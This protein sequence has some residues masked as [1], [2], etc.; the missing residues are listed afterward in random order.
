MNIRHPT[1]GAPGHGNAVAGGGVRVGGVQIDLARAAGGEHGLVGQ[2][3][4][5]LVGMAVQYIGP[6]A[7]RLGLTKLFAQDQVQ[8]D[9]V[10]QYFDIRVGQHL[11]R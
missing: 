5:D 6:Q 2:Q 3:G 11:G 4:F 8:T 7:A 9:M 1:A 10:F